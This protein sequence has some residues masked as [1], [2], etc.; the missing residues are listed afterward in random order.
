MDQESIDLIWGWIF[1]LISCVIL[2]Q[3]SKPLWDFKTSLPVNNRVKLQCF[4]KYGPQNTFI[5]FT[6]VSGF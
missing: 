3:S 6:Q 5:R 1:R 2:Q 4:S